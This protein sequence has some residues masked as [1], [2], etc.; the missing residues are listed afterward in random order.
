L[1]ERRAALPQ[2]QQQQQQQ[3]HLPLRLRSLAGNML[4]CQKRSSLRNMLL[5]QHS[6]SLA[7]AHVVVQ[8]SLPTSSLRGREQ[9]NASLP[10]S[11]PIGQSQSQPKMHNNHFIK[12]QKRMESLN[13][14][15][16]NRG[17][18]NA[19]IGRKY[20][21]GFSKFKILQFGKHKTIYFSTS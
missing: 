20:C 5:A 16:F 18:L 13:I 15:T 8:I 7:L 1:N 2:R 14:G 11:L 3:L 10:L 19:V 9:S 21:C 4:R 17:F 12:V 6:I